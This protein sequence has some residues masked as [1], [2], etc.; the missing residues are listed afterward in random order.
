[1]WNMFVV[2]LSECGSHR[3]HP[4]PGSDP[5]RNITSPHTYTEPK[6]NG[7]KKLNRI[8]PTWFLYLPSWRHQRADG[9]REMEEEE[10]QKQQPG[11]G[12][13]G[14]LGGD[15]VTVET[16][17]RMS[18]SVSL[19]KPSSCCQ[20]DFRGRKNHLL[21]R[22]NAAPWEAVAPP[23]PPPFP[24]GPPPLGVSLSSCQHH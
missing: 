10:E 13:G 24:P 20:I 9:H 5:L 18:L 4:P 17:G 12:G 6:Q 1:M 15:A 2:K 3:R 23:L 21:I 11:G 16:E 7:L 22:V 19:R 8:N 14:E